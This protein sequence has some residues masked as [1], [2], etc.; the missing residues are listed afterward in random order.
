MLTGRSELVDRAARS[1]PA[2]FIL[3]PWTPAIL[4]TP[5]SSGVVGARDS[6]KLSLWIDRS[7]NQTIVLDWELQPRSPMS[8]QNFALELPGNETTLL[9]LDVP[10]NWVPL[11]RRGRRRGP[12]STTAGQDQNRWEV[13]SESGKIDIQM[14][15][16]AG[17][18]RSWKRR[19]GFPDRRRLT[20]DAR[21]NA[22]EVWPTGRRNGGSRSIR[23]IPNHCESSLIR[24][25]S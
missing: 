13:E 20:C 3:E 14:Y 11:C 15:E 21:P 17:G 4:S 24:A 6:G 5:Q 9:T 12:L 25:W 23:A 8:G 1:G 18:V 10:K 19:H 16:Q 2:D 22:R 7:A